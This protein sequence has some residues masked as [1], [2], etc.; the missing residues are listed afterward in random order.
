MCGRACVERSSLASTAPPPPLP[1]PALLPHHFPLGLS[2][3]QR[4]RITLSR[5]AVRCSAPRLASRTLGRASCH[6]PSVHKPRPG[7]LTT[8]TCS[9]PPRFYLPPTHAPLPPRRAIASYLPLV[10]GNINTH[11]HTPLDAAAA[12]QRPRRNPNT[13]RQLGP[14]S[15]ATWFRPPLDHSRS[16]TAASHRDLPLSAP[17]VHTVQP[18]SLPSKRSQAKRGRPLLLRQSSS[19]ARKEAFDRRSA[20]MLSFFDLTL[21]FERP[22]SSS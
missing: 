18:P 15:Q 2:P 21:L 4:L 12:E 19:A 9:S 17:F 20:R 11:A 16:H 13:R 6:L 14:C 5:L 3:S 8:V 1:L 7:C 22:R 10:I